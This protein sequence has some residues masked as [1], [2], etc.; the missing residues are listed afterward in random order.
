M[1]EL[2]TELPSPKDQPALRRFRIILS[3]T[4]ATPAP[5]PSLWRWNQGSCSKISDNNNIFFLI[6]LSFVCQVFVFLFLCSLFPIVCVIN[7]TKVQHFW[8]LYCSNT[9]LS[10]FFFLFFFAVSSESFCHA[11]I[12]PTHTHKPLIL[13]TN[14]IH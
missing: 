6:V 4:T 5:P 12:T 10:F 13:Q 11:T 8:L 7:P 9:T 1:V 2:P 14:N 3:P